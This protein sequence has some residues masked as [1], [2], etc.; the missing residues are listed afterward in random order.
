MK[1]VASFLIL[2]FIA[3]SCKTGEKNPEEVIGAEKLSAEYYRTNY[4]YEG[5]GLKLDIGFILKGSGSYILFTGKN[6]IT[7]E[8]LMATGFITGMDVSTN[9]GFK[10]SLPDITIHSQTSSIYGTYC[11]ISGSE[12]KILPGL[13]L[14]DDAVQFERDDGEAI[15]T[16][17][18][19]GV[20]IEYGRESP[21]L[22]VLAFSSGSDP[23][24]DER[25]A[26]Q[27]VA[28]SSGEKSKEDTFVVVS[29]DDENESGI[30]H[31]LAENYDMIESIDGVTCQAYGIEPVYSK[32]S[33]K[34]IRNSLIMKVCKDDGCTFLPSEENIENNKEYNILTF[35]NFKLNLAERK[36]DP[37]CKT[38]ANEHFDEDADTF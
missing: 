16:M 14:S 36:L 37:N 15:M 9:V 7:D 18:S 34:K 12:A 30:T 33:G 24:E 35:H 23:E 29:G 13:D 11:T 10:I 2:G 20:G 17:S 26:I 1:F 6:L 32:T 38:L 19:P 22:T 3:L 25:P 27:P 31:P 5:S 28:N 8:S 4:I 21:C